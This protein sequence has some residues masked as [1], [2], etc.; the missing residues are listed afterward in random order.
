[1]ET[2]TGDLQSVK[3]IC[4]GE[5]KQTSYHRKLISELVRGMIPE[6]WIGRYSVP[7]GCTVINWINDFAQSMEN[8][9]CINPDYCLIVRKNGQNNGVEKKRTSKT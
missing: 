7:N 2:V 4:Q 1:L 5:K 6:S 9:I 3:M 8:S